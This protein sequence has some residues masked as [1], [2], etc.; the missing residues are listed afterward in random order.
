ME[1]NCTK[2][3]LF[4][5]EKTSYRIELNNINLMIQAS[6]RLSSITHWYYS[7]ITDTVVYL[8]LTKE[9]FG[10]YAIIHYLILF[11]RPE[12]FRMQIIV[13]QLLLN[14]EGAYIKETIKMTI[15]SE[16]K[17]L[18]N[19]QTKD[20]SIHYNRF[21]WSVY[22]V[23]LWRNGNMYSSFHSKTC[24]RTRSKVGDGSSPVFHMETN[25][26]YMFD[27]LIELLFKC[28]RSDNIT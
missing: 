5:L 24:S 1:N 9:C 14:I 21:S 15:C 12:E 16:N 19:K 10:S 11:W 2:A 6:A 25:K 23:H 3:V 13:C 4:H 7:L 27:W 20:I 22:I 28:K 8:H 17:N 26:N 18:A